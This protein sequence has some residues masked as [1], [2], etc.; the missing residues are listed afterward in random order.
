MATRKK[1]PPWN[2]SLPP[3]PWA[4]GGKPHVPV[5]APTTL[6]VGHSTPASMGELWRIRRTAADGTSALVT[7]AGEPW[8]GPALQAVKRAEVL[9]KEDP[10]GRY[11]A[12]RA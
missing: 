1:K 10:D 9:G 2:A 12:E 8:E 5:H 4:P 6:T 3:P 7:L 11:V